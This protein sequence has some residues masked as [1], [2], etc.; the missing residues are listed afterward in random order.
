[1]VAKVLALMLSPIVRLISW[2]YSLVAGLLSYGLFGMALVC[3][4]ATGAELFAYHAMTQEAWMYLALAVGSYVARWAV[5]LSAGL[6]FALQEAVE[7]RAHSPV[8]A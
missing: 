3:L 5:L 8:K 7:I 6:L 4:F 2:I 1:M